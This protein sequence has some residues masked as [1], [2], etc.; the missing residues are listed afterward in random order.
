MAVE[1]CPLTTHIHTKTHTHTSNKHFLKFGSFYA[2]ESYKVQGN[3][4]RKAIILTTDFMKTLTSRR[5][6]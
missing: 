1:S 2:L 4:T 5:I 3:Q 6:I